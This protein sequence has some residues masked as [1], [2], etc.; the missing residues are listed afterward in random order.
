MFEI[1]PYNPGRSKFW[2][3]RNDARAQPQPW[4]WPLARL[5]DRDPIV[6]AEGVN[7]DRLAADLGYEARPFDRELYVPVQATQDGEVVMA[8]ETTS[9]FFV[10]IEHGYRSLTTT[11]ARMSQ[12]FVTPYFGQVNRRRQRVRC[13]DVVGYAAK[14]PIAVRFEV[15]RWTETGGYSAID[16]VAQLTEWFSPLTH[17]MPIPDKQAA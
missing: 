6:L 12:M 5:G 15:W 10:S 2:R 1:E 7:G 14:S 8:T 13:G 4:R 17:P 16:P 3:L 11:Y 9:G